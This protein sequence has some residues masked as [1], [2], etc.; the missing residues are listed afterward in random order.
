M[1]KLWI[2][3]DF[4]SFVQILLAVLASLAPSR[5]AEKIRFW[6][7]VALVVTVYG[8]VEIAYRVFANRARFRRSGD[9]SDDVQLVHAFTSLVFYYDSRFT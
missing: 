1:F 2:D 6:L 8:N 3:R 7:T 4:F 9:I 5:N